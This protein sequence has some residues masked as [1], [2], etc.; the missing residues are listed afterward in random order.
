MIWVAVRLPSAA[1]GGRIIKEDSDNDGQPDRI[2]HLA[3]SGDVDQLEADTDG[4][5]KMDTFQYYKR[6]MVE[7]IE[8]DTDADGRIDERD[9]LT[10][11][12]TTTRHSLGVNGEIVGT[13]T[14]DGEQRPL[15][16]RR[17]TTGDGRMD[18]VYHYEAGKL[19]IVTRDTTGDGRVNIRQRFRSEKPYEQT[20]DWNGDGQ[21]DQ[22]IRFDEQGRSVESR[23]DLD[24]DGRLETIRHYRNGE[25]DRQEGFISGRS[26]PDVVTEFAE[27]HAVS[28]Q[29]DTN[30]DGAFDVLVQ[31]SKGRPI[32]KEEDTNHDGRMDRF[33]AY[34]DR[35]RPLC[36]REFAANPDEP[37]KTTR[38]KAGELYS[39][40]QIVNGRQVFT[41]FQNDKPV[42]QTIDENR[43]G[44]PEQTITYDKQGRI[45]S[46]IGD[47]NRDGRI[48]SWHDYQQGA[49]H[50]TEQDR[51]HDGKVDAQSEYDG[52]RRVRLEMDNDGDGHFETRT[53]FDTA[54]WTKVT[55]IVDKQGRLGQR[56]SYSGE[57]L[58]K[59]EVF[60]AA[61]GR[62][63]KLEEFDQAGRIVMSKEA[64][65]GAGA[66]TL[67]WRYDEQENPVA[68]EKDSDGD[69][70]T[71]I[72]YHYENGRVK[73]VAEDRN[74]DGKPDLWETYDA[75]QVVVRRSEDLDFDGTADIEKRY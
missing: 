6:G 16:W 7:R 32:S 51:N 61:T 8:R 28:E 26:K 36:L 59:T 18:T 13:L 58:R 54:Q 41:R 46:A 31:M 67:T 11:G 37:V 53:V 21:I 4:D 34:D 20:A 55:E 69:G 35:G 62:L 50:R 24:R 63:S 19:R 39:V 29:R 64:E 17:D 27:G 66:L 14:F 65:N 2:V 1:A 75:G 43:D 5:L 30:A 33:T 25:L 9:L 49:L 71:D 68:A 23:H 47:T 52:G 72:W 40:E 12:K 74:K 38:F 15:E 45:D 73:T 3:P 44:R 60:D 57:V 70:A 10:D 22:A 56:M 48:D 42:K